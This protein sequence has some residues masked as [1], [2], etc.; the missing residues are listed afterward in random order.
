MSENQFMGE[1]I[2]AKDNYKETITTI[3]E[4]PNGEVTK[5]VEVKEGQTE[6]LEE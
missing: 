6:T 4:K 5:K 1:V 2:N 3:D